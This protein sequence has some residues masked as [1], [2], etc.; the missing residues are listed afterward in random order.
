MYAG[1]IVEDADVDTLFSDSMHP[2]TWG[3]M[4][5]IPKIGTKIKRLAT[6]PGVVPSSLNFPKG[7]KFNN[8]CLLT[9]EKC[10]NYEPDLTEIVCGHKVRCWHIER[11]DELKNKQRAI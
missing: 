2:Y 11:L 8:R 1:K 9:D 7:C 10:F 6:I 3:L 5:S 4:N